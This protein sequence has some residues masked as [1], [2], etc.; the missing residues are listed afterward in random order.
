M[1]NLTRVSTLQQ[2][3]NMANLNKLKNVGEDRS[4][5]ELLH[6][7]NGN[8]TF[9]KHIQKSTDTGGSSLSKVSN[10]GT[11]TK[12]FVRPG[13]SG[14]QTTVTPSGEV[15]RKNF[16]LKGP[17]TWAYDKSKTNLNASKKIKEAGVI[18]PGVNTTV[19]VNGQTEK[20][21]QVF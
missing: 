20:E 18:V 21:A 2:Y 13:G 14:T 15:S 8:R 19:D 11:T 17:Q 5:Q 3:T 6:V 7:N 1:I 9:R 10:Y 12:R 16:Q 4:L